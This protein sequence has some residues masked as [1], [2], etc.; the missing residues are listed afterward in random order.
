MWMSEIFERFAQESPLTVMV[1][2]LLEAALPPSGLDEL[3]E[4]TATVQY[5]RELL[6]SQLVG[7]MCQVT[8][9]IQPSVN[10]A[11]REQSTEI[12]VSRTALYN[13]LNRMETG[14]SRAL[15]QYTVQQLQPLIEQLG[16]QAHELLPGYR[17]KIL[18]GNCIGA[19]EHRLAILQ[20]ILSAP[21][22]GKSLVVL[23]PFLRLA[24]DM[25]PCEDGHA[26]ERTL[27]TNV[28]NTVAAKDLWIAGCLIFI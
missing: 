18:D 3:F 26:N 25:F 4:K 16:G 15:V 7:L 10:A 20:K 28:L 21:L 23:D 12:G 13:K 1:R 5:T 2:V 11:Y 14:V 22:P 24:I 8:C 19:S 6:F 9:G 27:F 17:V